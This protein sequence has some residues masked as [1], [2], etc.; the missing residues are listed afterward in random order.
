MLK[1][2]FSR[3][4]SK[5]VEISNIKAGISPLTNSNFSL[6]DKPQ[7]EPRHKVLFE[8]EKKVTDIIQ[9][10]GI[11]DFYAYNL[12]HN[13]SYDSEKLESESRKLEKYMRSRWA[14]ALFTL[15]KLLSNVN[16]Q[17]LSNERLFK[18]FV[19]AL[20][21]K[22][23]EKIVFELT[24]PSLA[25]IMRS[26]TP[27]SD[28]PRK[29]REEYRKQHPEEEDHFPDIVL[30]LSKVDLKKTDKNADFS[31]HEN[32]EVK[33]VVDEKQKS[34]IKNEEKKEI[35]TKTGE[36]PKKRSSTGFLDKKSLCKFPYRTD[37]DNPKYF[38]IK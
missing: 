17:S 35:A 30:K 32:E 4:R 14:T 31:T 10:C 34:P 29:I 13:S 11:D 28:A 12:D 18:L 27:P 26:K 38:L 9:K 24:N 1:S 20:K 6:K 23:K 3:F 2:H 15:R 37:L 19:A 8:E 22:I 25:K 36:I 16:V 21:E 5:S 33:V 7:L